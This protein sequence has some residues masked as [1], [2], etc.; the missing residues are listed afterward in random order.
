MNY[1]RVLCDCEMSTL[2][3]NKGVVFNSRGKVF[4]EQMDEFFGSQFS[5][6]CGVGRFLV[7]KRLLLGLR[8]Q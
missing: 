8:K 2:L 5:R 7:S 3:E 4:D 1:C 6:D